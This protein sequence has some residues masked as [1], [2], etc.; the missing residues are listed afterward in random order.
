MALAERVNVARRYQRAIS[1]DSDMS[2]PTALEGFICPRSSAEVLETMAH[3]VRAT[4]QVPS[5]GRAPT[6][7]ASRA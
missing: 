7:Q 2:D 5:P 1:I 4:G 6:A 3:H